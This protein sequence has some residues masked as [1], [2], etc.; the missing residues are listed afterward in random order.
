MN[1]SEF[2]NGLR[3]DGYEA[4]ERRMAADTTNPAHAHEFDARLLILDGEITITRDGSTQTYRGGDTFEMPAGC[5]HAEQCGP[6][7]VGYIAGRRF[8]AKA[9][10]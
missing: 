8:A 4:V 6:A 9:A 1:R 5:V 2:E 7:G 10:G 3:R